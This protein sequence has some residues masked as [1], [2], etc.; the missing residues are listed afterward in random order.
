MNTISRVGVDLAKHA[1]KVQ[2]AAAICEAASR[3]Q[4]HF[5]PT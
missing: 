2:D 1:L 5:V 4:M 3:P